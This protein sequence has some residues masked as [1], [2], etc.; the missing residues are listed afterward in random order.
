M[1]LYTHYTIYYIVYTVSVCLIWFLFTIPICSWML[2]SWLHLFIMFT[3]CIKS[4]TY[5]SIPMYPWSSWS[6]HTRVHLTGIHSQNTSSETLHIATRRWIWLRYLA[7]GWV[8]IRSLTLWCLFEWL[9]TFCKMWLFQ[10]SKG[11]TP[12]ISPSAHLQQELAPQPGMH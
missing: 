10:W 9:K 1:G 4:Q 3:L 2:R 11:D 5:R 12:A 7:C 6:L 8:W